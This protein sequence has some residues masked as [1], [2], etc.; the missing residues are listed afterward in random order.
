M[1]VFEPE[2][3]RQQCAAT[4]NDS[5]ERA[6]FVTTWKKSA[7]RRA[8]GW[9]NH[10]EHQSKHPL[11]LEWI[12]EY[13]EYLTA[14]ANTV[15]SSQGSD[16]TV[17]L[18]PRWPII[19]P[20]AEPPS[21]LHQFLC[22]VTPEIEPDTTYLKPCYTVHWLFHDTLRRCPKCNSKRLER[23]GW[24]PSGPREVHGLRREEMA[25]GIQ[26]RCLDCADKYAKKGQTRSEDAEGRYCWTGT[27]AEFWDNFEHWELPIGLP[28]F[29]SRSAVSAEL[30]DFIIEMRL[31]STSAGLAENIKQFHLL[32]YH[33]QHY[34]YLQSYR[35]RS[36]QTSFFKQKKPLVPYS[37]PV[38]KKV[39]KQTG[40]YDNRSI[41]DD[42]VTAILL[43]F[44]NKTRIEESEE[45]MRSLSAV[46][47]SIDT[48][49]RCAYKATLVDKNKARVKSHLGGFV[50]VI[51]QKSQPISWRLCHS[52]SQ[53]E[54]QE[55]LGGLSTRFAHLELSPPEVMTSDNC[56]QIRN[57]VKKVFPDTQVVQD[58]WHFLMRYMNCVKDGTKN[59]HRSEAAN[60]IVN[61]ILKVRAANGVPAM[62]HSQPEQERRLI[63][64]YTKWEDRGGVWTAAA[65]K[66]HAKQL[67]HVRKGCLARP[68]DDIPT[69]GSRIE[70]SH[71]GWNSIMRSFASGL[72]VMNALG[73][74]HVL[75]HNVRLDMADDNLDRSMFT[76]HT[77]G[78]HH[79]RLTN[80]CAKLWNV[81]LEAQKKKATRSSNLRPLPELCPADSGE[82]FGLV[83][84]STET[85]TQYSL[86]AIKQE[87][88]DEEINL[89]L[90]DVLDAD[91]ILEEIGVDP[92]L[93]NAPTPTPKALPP[94]QPEDPDPKVD[95]KGK[96]VKCVREE[97]PG[98]D[99]DIV[100]LS[101]AEW[102]VPN[103]WFPA[104]P[105]IASTS[106]AAF[107][108]TSTST[109][110]SSMTAFMV[111]GAPI[112]PSC[113]VLPPAPASTTTLGALTTTTSNASTALSLSAPT[114]TSNA[115]ALAALP[116]P[117]AP[118]TIAPS[119]LSIANSTQ[120]NALAST[121]TSS[122]ISSASIDLTDGPPPKK[123]V[124]LT[125]PGMPPPMKKQNGGD[126][127]GSASTTSRAKS[128][129]VWSGCGTLDAMFAQ[130]PASTTPTTTP[131][132]HAAPLNV[133]LTPSNEPCLPRPVIVGLTRSQRLF[134][135]VTQ[136]DPRALTF[137]RGSSHEF[138][139]FMQ[140]RATHQWATFQMT[141]YDWV[142]AASTYN[143]A[144][145]RLN[146]ER[147]TT[148]S[149]K[150]PRALL[151]KLS[152]VEGWI[153]GR[154]WDTN[155]QSRSGATHFWEHHC[156][157]VYLGSK[158]Q[159]MV[160]DETFKMGKNHICGRC[161]RIMYPEGKN[162]KDN[163]SR[164]ICSDGVRQ[165]PQKVHLVINGIAR[166]FVEAPP[167]FPQPDNVFTG[168][169]VFHPAH[170][171]EVVRR[172]YDRIVINHSAPGAL[173]M[174]DYAFAALLYDRTV[175]VPGLDGRPSKVIFKLF[176]SFKMA[177]GE[178]VVL[179]EHEGEKY[180]RMDCLSEPP[181]E[182][183]QDAAG[184]GLGSGGPA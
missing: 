58:V 95:M 161:K 126:Q 11:L 98:E 57:T 150:T 154:I 137:G 35:A 96:G 84:M 97:D 27:S 111:S 138:F 128:R 2:Y 76:F 181:L 10:R 43:K 69:D 33:K 184:D 49:F 74:D 44:C 140:L 182:V 17:A 170:F 145:K 24:N 52:Q 25:I 54:T 105:A 28:H 53:T 102:R 15:Q 72:E 5:E 134:S 149:L 120:P 31:K 7:E 141:P 56:C 63:E 103:T 14:T 119:T 110:S 157:V 101:A 82:K 46:T 60:D 16:L 47:A 12:A 172:F 70:G 112:I 85:A 117:P 178:A 48:T 71:K 169:D 135:V 36:Q 121:S 30:F 109:A 19:G 167:P 23:N 144:I 90:Q 94:P 115:L 55:M 93:V 79:I 13:A 160:D 131:T 6:K 37:K 92:A 163:H 180:L 22:Q 78:S 18:D 106:D 139:L 165:S 50:S 87:V 86:T 166:D 32:E 21:Y 8:N 4:I 146:L 124:C 89:T 122:G 81:L 129:Q 173:A 130:T 156:K 39:A 114:V 148:Y 67:E 34:L 59:P 175:I 100:E 125:V 64:A 99:D 142:C 118:P 177:P 66:V 62:Y 171:M 61:A 45:H 153:F 183:L 42:L 65:A 176:H 91:C 127:D 1:G 77:Y 3:V 41:S 73:H 116:A 133:T 179:D 51:N 9:K 113:I 174:T 75:R 123:R 38:T 26:I 40:G 68:R 168:G 158:I 159:R 104:S 155:Y 164:K 20:K 108:S 29:F 83:K 132:P 88:N 162:H 107:A 136:V 152:E 143:T 151:D 80:A 147:A